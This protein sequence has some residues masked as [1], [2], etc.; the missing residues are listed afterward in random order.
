MLAR[1]KDIIAIMEEHFPL[2]LAE[3]WDNPGLQVGSRN[4]AVERLVVALDMDEAVLHYAVENRAGMIVTHHPLFFKGLK[5]IDYDHMPGR[6]LAG[7]V[8]NNLNVY[9]AHTNL[10]AGDRGLN[11]ILAE[12]LGLMDIKPLQPSFVEPLYKLVVYVP[13]GYENQIREAV[14]N[15]GAG[16]IGRYSGCSFRSQGTGT[17]IPTEGTNP[18]IG[19]TGRLEEVQEYRLETIVGKSKLGQVVSRMLEA[20]PYEEPAYDLY[21]LENTGKVFSLGRTGRLNTE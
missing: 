13:A 8:Q 15:A 12:R 20:H 6:L 9:S 10:D 14:S 17:F 5:K 11:Q 19:T 7:I 2:H 1:V 4:A 18:F 3:S 16:H 21:L